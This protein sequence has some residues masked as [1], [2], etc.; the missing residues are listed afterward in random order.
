MLPGLGKAGTIPW[1]TASGSWGPAR[2]SSCA[3]GLGGAA[4]RPAPRLPPRRREP[5]ARGPARA[6][7]S[8]ARPAAQPLEVALDLYRV[9]RISHL[10]S[11]HTITRCY[12]E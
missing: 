6:L 12:T 5:P 2:L 9:L 3:A 8:A 11:A 1:L 4:S 10:A 7:L